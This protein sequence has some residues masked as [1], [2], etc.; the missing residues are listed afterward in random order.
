MSIFELVH[1]HFSNQ[2]GRPMQTLAQGKPFSIVRVGANEN[3]RTV[4]TV[5]ELRNSKGT[6]QLVYI[7]DLIKVY[8]LLIRVSDNW[9]TLSEI[10]KTVDINKAQAPYLAPMLATF[11]D[12]E[13]RR[14]P[15]VALRFVLP[16]GLIL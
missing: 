9:L 12:V 1:T 3:K 2:I 14:K 8:F 16:K 13:A 15:T 11:S 10:I 4:H 6:P 7:S 5:I